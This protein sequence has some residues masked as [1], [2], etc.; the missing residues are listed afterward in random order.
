MASVTTSPIERL[1]QPA[2]GPAALVRPR[3]RLGRLTDDGP[4]D[5]LELGVEVVDL[6]LD[7]RIR[8]DADR[9]RAVE[10]GARVDRLLPVAGSTT[11]L[12]RVKRR[13]LLRFSTSSVPFERRLSAWK[14]VWSAMTTSTLET[15]SARSTAG[16]VGA[17]SVPAVAPRWPIATMVPIF[18]LSSWDARLFTASVA[19][20]T[21]NG[22]NESGKTRV[23]ASSL[24]K[25]M[26]P[27]L[28]PS[29]VKFRLF[30]HSAGGSP[31]AGSMTFADTNLKS[32]SGISVSRRYSWPLSKL[33][34]PRPS[35][36]MPMRFIMLHRR[37]V[38]EE[39]ADRRA[40]RP[41]NHRRRP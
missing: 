31:V 22:S 16:P 10:V 5:R 34:L 37:R 30:D 35:R 29:S 33:W 6:G 20:V 9:P 2:V 38:A 4:E 1:A 41:P 32:A 25:P 24:V 39:G 17:V 13:P 36:S 14:S 11:M 3:D 26:I 15:L 28:M 21:T 18:C 7:G 8:R 19:F 12:T 23:G 40:S 27:I